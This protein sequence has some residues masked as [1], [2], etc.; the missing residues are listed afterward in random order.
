MELD[1]NFVPLDLITRECVHVCLC[2]CECASVH[3][4]TLRGLM[5]HKSILVL[6]RGNAERIIT[7]SE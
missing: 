5:N 7:V 6:E 4:W 1:I 3:V 2:V